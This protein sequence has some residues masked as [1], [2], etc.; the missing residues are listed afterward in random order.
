MPACK[1]DASRKYKGDEP[2]PKGLGWCAHT[3]TA[4]ATRKGKDGRKWTVALD[5][6]GTKSWKVANKA[7]AKAEESPIK[8]QVPPLVKGAPPMTLTKSITFSDGKSLS[9]GIGSHEPQLYDHETGDFSPMT[10]AHWDAV[11]SP[12]D[13]VLRLDR[14][15]PL[16]YIDVDVKG[17]A[18]IGKVVLAMHKFYSTKLSSA[19][20]KV[21]ETQLWRW[22]PDDDGTPT[23]LTS[24]KKR[25]R[26]YGDSKGDHTALSGFDGGLMARFNPFSNVYRPYWDS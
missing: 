2:S 21:L 17:P 15:D 22:S 10:R 18:T 13:I 3:E 1:N 6:N 7:S 19:D 11:M 25:V 5:K 8:L 4:G 14:G 23:T 20:Y 9:W 26:T 12:R 24:L 16:P